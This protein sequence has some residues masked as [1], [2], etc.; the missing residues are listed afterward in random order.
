MNAS[1]AVKLVLILSLILVSIVVTVLCQPYYGEPLKKTDD[2]IHNAGYSSE[3]YEIFTKDGY[4]LKIFRITGLLAQND[5]ATNSSDVN[6]KPVVLLMHGLTS[7]SDCWVIAGLKNSLAFE[8]VDQGYDVWLG[9]NRGNNYG[10]NHLNISSNDREFWRFTFHEIGTIDLPTMIDFILEKTQKEQLHYIGHSQGTT[11]AMALLSTLPEYNKKMKSICFLA[12]VAFLDNVNSYLVRALSGLLGIYTP[13]HAF[14]GDTVVYGQR[15]IRQLLG[16][17]RCRGHDANP[18]I[19][20]FLIY[21][22]YGGY[23]AYLDEVML[24]DL[25]DSHP[26]TASLH[27]A[28]HYMQIRH[29]GKFLHYNLG[30]S[31]NQRR[32]NQSKPPEYNLTNIN[33]RFPIQLFYSDY[34]N[35]A[36]KKDAEKIADILGNRSSSHFIDI[37]YFA[38]IDFILGSQ[39]ENTVNRPIIEIIKEA[40]KY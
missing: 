7:S 35:L 23:S 31:E 25:F 21:R 16:F 40:E 36:S 5:K 33:P 28:L 38:H 30:S 11:S 3:S 15:F 17:E 39:K 13:L 20:S 4:G 37:E 10:K 34:D 1:L 26:S 14:L 27:Q 6:T 2:R 24:P 29:T 32:Y 8:L 12:P 18:K 19:C 9:N 22:L